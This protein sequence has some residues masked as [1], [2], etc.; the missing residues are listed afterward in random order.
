MLSRLTPALLLALPS[1]PAL[2]PCLLAWLY[3]HKVLHNLESPK[4][5]A[6]ISHQSHSHSNDD[7][8]YSE[9]ILYHILQHKSG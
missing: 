8:A 2:L 6:F 7:L 4:P 5:S 1:C 3:V 9:L